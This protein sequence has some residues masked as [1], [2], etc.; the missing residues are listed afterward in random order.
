V[1]TKEWAGKTSKRLGLDESG[2]IELVTASRAGD[3]DALDALVRVLLD[4]VY[5]LALRMTANVAD[6]EDATQE[7]MI[8]VV[9]R[10]DSFRGEASVRTWAYRIAVHHLLDRKKSRVESLAL[11]FEQFASDLHEGLAQTAVRE[12][13][14]VV[15]EVKLGCTLAMMT[16]LDRDHR[17][18]YLLGD[19]F[20]LQSDLAAS[21]AGVTR[22]VHR[23]R[24][25]RARR[26][27]EAFTRTYCG[28]VNPQ[29]ACACDRRVKR[30]VELGRVHRD[31]LV[32]AKHPRRDL[33]SGVREMDDLHATAALFRS[34]PDYTAP[35]KLA[36]AIRD[37]VATKRL[38]IL[39]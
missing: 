5:G 30:A 28:I 36:A 12:D 4:D 39:R 29:A 1:T 7:V 14:A 2:L 25:S 20:D 6:A 9:T 15:E 37:V 21:I 33:L 11:D 23:Q 22:D 31:H 17:I 18:A 8:K 35:E 3:P 24:L 10:L 13:P 32:L 34:H 27:L 38:E 16:C 26:Q 19:V